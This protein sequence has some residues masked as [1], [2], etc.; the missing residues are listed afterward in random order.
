MEKIDITSELERLDNHLSGNK[1]TILSAKFGDG[2]S[3]FLNEY[4][5]TRGNEKL[6]ITLH[7]VNYV[8]APNEDVF[9]YIKRDI[10]KE[11]CQY[12]LVTDDMLSKILSGVVNKDN[13]WAAVG[14]L[15]HVLLPFG[16]GEASKDLLKDFVTNY[17]KNVE[18]VQSYFSGF[19]NQ[20]GGIYEEDA[21]TVMIKEAV[22]HVQTRDDDPKQVVLIIEDLD[23]IDPGHLFRI[24][25][26]LGAHIDV[27]P[28]KNKFGFDNIILV[29]DY[30]V[31]RTIFY[32]F[33]GEKAN[34]EGY[35]AKFKSSHV[36]RFSITRLAQQLLMT[37]MRILAGD[38][39]LKV[40]VMGRHS[41]MNSLSIL[42]KI[43]Q[44]SVRK[45]EHI[46]DR[47]DTM[48]PEYVERKDGLKLKARVP[49]TYLVALLV[50]M[51]D[52][53]SRASI[54][55]TFEGENWL[56]NLGPLVYMKDSVEHYPISF[57]TSYCQV[58][59]SRESGPVV[60]A[61]DWNICY[62]T[63]EE[64][65]HAIRRTEIVDFVFDYAMAIVADAQGIKFVIG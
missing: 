52:S 60:D 27:E 19:T 57:G 56:R 63:S 15:A 32:H 22:Q 41:A 14:F 48:V 6:F 38:G 54:M 24:L 26:V 37:K 10:L 7:P 51:D 31:T 45:V 65:K 53:Y 64:Q 3:Y 34:Y 42:D 2:K 47:I 49:L 62:P 12:R 28:D 4:V 43:R 55:E 39:I 46:M 21:Y 36:F 35:M 17:K 13:A 5:R 44:L 25:N 30:D 50:L 33:Y 61:L 1:R 16:I 59:L 20:R 8:V 9:E 29:L 58:N 23:R 40:L 18:D 11:L